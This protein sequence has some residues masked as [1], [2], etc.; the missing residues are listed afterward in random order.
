VAA[1][2]VTVRREAGTGRTTVAVGLHSDVD[3]LPHEHEA[4]HR[5]LAAALLPS[6]G[7]RRDRPA[8]EAAVG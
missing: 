3:A 4:L 1:L 6:P 2:T 5:R 8:R 7:V